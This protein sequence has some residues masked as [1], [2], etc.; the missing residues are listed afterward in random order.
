[1]NR[2][3]KI[4][5]TALLLV[6]YQM[7]WAREDV[8][9]RR[10]TS[11]TTPGSGRISSNCLQ[12]SSRVFMDINNVRALML[13]GGDMWWDLNSNPQYE[14]PKQ[15]DVTQTKRH[16]LFAGSL[17]IGGQSPSGNLLVAAQTYRQGIYTFWPGPVDAQTRDVTAAECL[18]FNRHFKVNVS[19][20]DEFFSDFIEGR[21]S[22]DNDIPDVIKFW[23]AK[24]NPFLSQDPNFNG[25]NVNRDLAPFKDFDG[26]PN[27][28]NPLEGDRPD[29][30]GQ[31]MV[32]W[33]M[34][35]VGNLK[36][37]GAGPS[38]QA[39]GMEIRVEAFGYQ[40]ADDRNDM[41]FYRNRLYNRGVDIM[42]NTH[43]GQWADPDLGFAGDDYVGCDVPRGLGVCY[44]GDGFD[45]GVVGYGT[46]LPLVGIDFFIGPIAD[47]I[48]LIDNNKD[49]RI[50]ESEPVDLG[51]SGEIRFG[52]PIIM[53]NFLY[54]NNTGDPVNGNPNSVSDYY[55]YLR[56]RWRTGER[57]TYD[58][59]AGRTTWDPAI[60]P[61]SAV[62]CQT[63]FIFPGFSDPNSD[64]Q[65]HSDAQFFWSCNGSVQ[66]PGGPFNYP[67]PNTFLWNERIAGNA[68]GDRR[69]LQS[70]GPFTLEPGAKNEVTTAVVWTQGNIAAL[71]AASDKAQKL[72]DRCFDNLEGPNSPDMVV[73]ELDREV[74]LSLIPDEFFTEEGV[75][76][77]TLT[78]EEVDKSLSTVDGDV[79]YRF[80]G[81]KVYQV[82]DNTVTFSEFNDPSKARLISQ[83]DIQDGVGTIINQLPS[84]WDADLLVPTLMV[85]GADK[86][87]VNSI[88]V[89]N[90]QFS[91]LSDRR[92]I[93]YK[94]YYFAV[95][96]Y[97][98]VANSKTT[99]PYIL[100]SKNTRIYTAVPSK[101]I[102]TIL[103]S[104]PGDPV[105][106]SRFAGVG[107]DGSEIEIT[108]ET[109]DSIVNNWK[110]SKV[111]YSKGPFSV[112]IYDPIRA[113]D[114]KLKLALFSRLEYNLLST[115][116]TI[117][118]GDTLVCTG[119]F[120]VPAGGVSPRTSV[121]IRQIPGIAVVR[122]VVARKVDV[123]TGFPVAV[124]QVQ[125]LNDHLGGT[126]KRLDDILQD[127]G[128]LRTVETP[129]TFLKTRKLDTA[130]VTQ[131]ELSDYFE[132]EVINGPDLGIINNNTPI[133]RGNDQLIPELG[134][135]ITLRRTL[136]PTEKA[137][138][139]NVTSGL[140]RAS[141]VFPDSTKQW[142]TTIVD[143]TFA[144]RDGALSDAELNVQRQD[145]IQFIRRQMLNGSIIPY[146]FA[147]P[148]NRTPVGNQNVSV[149]DQFAASYAEGAQPNFRF[150]MSQTTRIGN[151]DIVITPDQTKWT[152]AAVLQHQFRRS[153]GPGSAQGLNQNRFRL[154]KSNKVSL[155]RNLVTDSTIFSPFNSNL[156]SRGMSWF[157]GYAIDLDRGIRLNIAFAEDRNR[158][159]TLGIGND[160]KWDPSEARDGDNNFIYIFNTPYDGGINIERELDSLAPSNSASVNQLNQFNY[161]M[162]RIDYA[163][164]F[165]AK[166]GF[167]PL[168]S[169]ATVKLRFQKTFASA[170]GGKGGVY[171]FEIKNKAPQ[172]S[173]NSLLK[174]Q[175]EIIR[176][177]PN[178]Y[179]SYSQ[180][181]RNQ[182]DN[183]VKMLNLPPRVSINIFTINGTLVR[184]FEKDDPATW[185]D[186][187]LRNQEGIPVAGGVYIM[188][189]NVPGV[190]EKTIKWF[191]V[192]RPLDLD[193]F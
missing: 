169:E 145:P 56:N 43:M 177:A 99:E 47:P 146:M 60:H 64:E 74:I 106:I 35:D 49:G 89:I 127:G 31:Q 175:L 48:D 140:L 50:D 110:V 14:V 61:N 105:A 85:Q 180:Y 193:T 76:Q 79:A 44:N 141:L 16:S 150:R 37:F 72:F 75:R 40:A 192:T 77:N 46:N 151:I 71:L 84:S 163:C 7:V 101:R 88:R 117:S 148:I 129:L 97:G 125:M 173:V 1:M 53:S 152:R 6:F 190:G 81:Y 164:L 90:D 191:G 62:L 170:E 91:T 80:Q 13:N 92:L 155:D 144:F 166:P 108:K 2:M 159:T 115:E 188:H 111:D 165:R 29:V 38:S 78:Y 122:R 83:S 32:W 158:N 137:S 186:W 39:I 51:C 184:R 66:D 23:P 167:L 113:R 30:R 22:S 136:N 133:S 124:L 27:Q 134:L 132:T 178:P 189:F 183:R 131:F 153:E 102:G 17:W 157:P 104:K 185:V 21:I 109:R 68:P 142:L 67:S 123:K 107:N 65:Y 58:F 9:A 19:E 63:N 45:D 12:S 28:Y 100:G 187:D 94:T 36:T 70:A 160:L 179:Y 42:L 95:V 116:D 55:N 41:T 93:N 181:E 3:S 20:V 171:T 128:F 11:G 156:R 25:I 54:Y 149:T 5:A 73:T 119:S 139:G 112:K 34:N 114:A 24:N 59:I 130:E 98:Y 33:I 172:L 4:I 135:Q 26:N 147:E 162:N 87:V 126:F 103:N 15:D 182:V 82:I 18:A 96:A 174:E 10:N 176:V 120:T 154:L 138:E 8:N 121:S 52:E 161:Y 69:F 57:V 118:V 143:T 86:G 168:E